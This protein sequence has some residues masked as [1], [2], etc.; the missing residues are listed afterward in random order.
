[1]RSELATA[2]AP[3]FG[4]LEQRLERL[5]AELETLRGRLSATPYMSAPPEAWPALRLSTPDDFD[6]LGF[7]DV[8]RGPEPFI[9]ERL[10]AY[11][12]LIA[13]RA[14]VV[15]LGSG[16]GEFLEIM[17][18]SGIAAT[19]VDLNAHAVARV[20]ANG[21]DNVVVGDANAY[22]AGLKES[23]V[24]AIFS[25]QFAEHLPFAELLRCLELARTRLVPGGVFIAETVNPN[26]IE[27]W[28]TFYVD[29]SHEKP[30]FPEIFLFL[31]RSM[32]FSDVRIFYPNGGGFAE[33]APTEQHEYAVVATAPTRDGS[34]TAAPPSVPNGPRRRKKARRRKRGDRRR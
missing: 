22:L 9:R 14:P 17:R 29:L 33:A 20:R 18:E 12:P 7:E 23:S 27:A 8:F 21:L 4:V 34:R 32:G 30:L 15:E 2:R 28:K 11:V 31:C 24:G 6:Y 25:A 19:G 10:R 1:M 16:R 13:G 5:A 26:S 3:E